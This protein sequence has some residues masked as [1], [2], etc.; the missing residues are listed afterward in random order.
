MFHFARLA[1][2]SGLMALL[3][4]IAML[5][6]FFMLVV[7]VLFSFAAM[8]DDKKY[9]AIIQDLHDAHNSRHG[10]A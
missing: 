9:L 1:R 7:V 8:G 2:V 5:M 10:P 4:P 3:L 6:V